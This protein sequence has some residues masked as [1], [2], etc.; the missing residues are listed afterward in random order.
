MKKELWWQGFH[1][2]PRLKYRHFKISWKEL[3]EEHSRSFIKTHFEINVCICV[4]INNQ[5]YWRKYNT[6]AKNNFKRKMN[7]QQCLN[8]FSWH[9]SFLPFKRKFRWNQVDCLLCNLVLAEPWLVMELVPYKP[10]SPIFG[11]SLGS[12]MSLCPRPLW[13]TAAFWV[14]A[15]APCLPSSQ[16]FWGSAFSSAFAPLGHHQNSHSEHPLLLKEENSTSQ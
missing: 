12:L 7:P 6:E 16:W 14:R 3:F 5:F 4:V 15:G 2:V 13:M 1:P 9:F 10:F 11:C 8:G